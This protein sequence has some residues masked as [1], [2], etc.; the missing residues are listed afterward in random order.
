M[1]PTISRRRVLAGLAGVAGL[2]LTPA[3]LS[4]CASATKSPS[5]AG[6]GKQPATTVGS[7]YSDPVPRAAMEDLIAAFAASTGLTA[8]LNTVDNASFQNGI[9][10]YL[11]GTPDDTFTWFAGNRMRFFA[12][13]GLAG[14]LSDIWPRIKDNFS[15][16]AQLASTA[17]D[18]KPYFVPFHTYPWVLIH[19][20]SLW[21]RHGY[22]APA[23]IDELV[24]LAGRMQKDGL[25]PFAFGDKDGWPA[26]GTF[27][28]LDLRLN[29]YDFHVGLATGRERWTDG[30]VRDVFDAWRRLL[31][32]HQ[33]GALGRTWQEAA[34]SLINGEAGMYF[35]GTFTGEQTDDAGR[36]DLELLA[37]PR[38]GTQFD[39]ERAIDAPING[40]MVSRAPASPDVAKAFLTYVAGGEAQT[41]YV[42]ANPNRIALARDADTSGYTAFQVKMRDAIAGAGRLAQFLDRDSRPDFTGPTGM[43]RFL[44]DFIADPDQDLDGFL[45]R[46]QAFWDSLP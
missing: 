8:V 34:K 24:A 45:A 46:I 16:G 38:A 40:F 4:A 28:I 17:A 5:P 37:F 32:L 6:S 35:A 13:Q 39:D 26:M 21:E 1:N 7:Y 44:Q 31:P 15:E 14:A 11:Q 22:E 18:G 23:T 25:V 30:R 12:A 41:M 20:K 27:D 43:Q 19:K 33:Q 9:N 3:V 36:E 42:T 10:A 29:G 2:T